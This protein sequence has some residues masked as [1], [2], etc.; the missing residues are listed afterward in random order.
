MR[1]TTGIAVL[2]MMMLAHPFVARA[3]LGGDATSV[4]ND[5]A[6]MR[7]SVRS[8]Q[9]A[10]AYT[11]QEIQTP[12][13]TVI[14]EYVS[15]AGKVFAVSWEGPFLPDLQ[16]LLGSYF[17][18][19]SQAVQARGPR[20]RGPVLINQPGLVVESGGHMRAFVGRAYVPGMLPEG[21]RAEDIH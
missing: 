16:Q 5:Q 21:V 19:F 9:Q 10:T 11:R 18:Q 3:E 4:Q 17:D 13:G 8:V 1:W 12:S 15:P 20:R 7:A 2:A 14:R 6:R